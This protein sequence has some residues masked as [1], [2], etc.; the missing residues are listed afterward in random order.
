[1]SKY[2]HIKSLQ[3]G[4]MTVCGKVIKDDSPVYDKDTAANMVKTQKGV[5]CPKCA[6]HK[7]KKQ[8]EAFPN[9]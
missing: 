3:A 5:L 8:L 1:M 7:Q 2:I 6:R 4:G 9:A